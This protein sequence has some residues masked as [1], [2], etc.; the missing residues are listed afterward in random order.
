MVKLLCLMILIRSFTKLLFLEVVK[1]ILDQFQP[2]NYRPRI[3]HRRYPTPSEMGDKR[4]VFTDKAPQPRSVYSQAI[5]AN[6]FIFCSGQLPK[7]LSGNVV[8]GTVQDRAVSWYPTIGRL[9]AK[10]SPL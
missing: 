10:D 4:A 9:H 3:P 5:V 2:G 8:E 6:G 7:D 1:D